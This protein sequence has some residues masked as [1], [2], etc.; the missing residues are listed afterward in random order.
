MNNLIDNSSDKYF[1]RCFILGSLKDQAALL[2]RFELLTNSD[3]N[4]IE[5]MIGEVYNVVDPDHV[6]KYHKHDY[7]KLIFNI[8]SLYVLTTKY[9]NILIISYSCNKNWTRTHIPSKL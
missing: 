7:F 9:S 2:V 6:A 5:I 8:G 1:L 3:M 4:D